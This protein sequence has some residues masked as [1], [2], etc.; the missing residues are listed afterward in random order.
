MAQ[1]CMLL[2]VVFRPIEIR[3]C[4]IE[5]ENKKQN[6]IKKQ[7]D[8]SSLTKSVCYR[9]WLIYLENKYLLMSRYIFMELCK[10]KKEKTIAI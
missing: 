1:L 4:S 2:I 3:T 7:C 10:F 8:L 9:N 6:K 5:K